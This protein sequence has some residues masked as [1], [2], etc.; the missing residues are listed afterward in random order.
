MTA[1]IDFLRL[2][3]EDEDD[4]ATRLIYADWLEENGE[5]EEA[6]RMRLW[7]G[8]K[9]RIMD[10]LA[11]QELVV[12]EAMWSYARLMDHVHREV[13]RAT[14]GAGNIDWGSVGICLG[15]AMELGY[16]LDDSE[17]AFWPNWS[18]VTGIPL[19]QKAPAARFYC[20]C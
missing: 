17:Q 3:H 2:L 13:T 12:D 4:G 18:I 9:Q 5:P 8:A 6:V 19:P 10:I 7:Q 11:L 16:A 20:S 1:R 15:D 14:D